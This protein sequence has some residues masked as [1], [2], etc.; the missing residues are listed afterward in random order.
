[1]LFEFATEQKTISQSYSRPSGAGGSSLCVVFCLFFK[2]SEL[3][4]G[5]LSRAVKRFFDAGWVNRLHGVPFLLLF[6]IRVKLGLELCY[7][8]VSYLI[9]V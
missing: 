4:F 3:W 8:F 1:M 7:V 2:E 5:F 6:E 9:A